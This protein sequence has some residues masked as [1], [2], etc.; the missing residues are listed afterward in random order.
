MRNMTIG[1]AIAKLEAIHTHKPL[2]AR[3]DFCMAVPTLGGSYRGT[4]REFALG[5]MGEDAYYMGVNGSDPRPRDEY[6]LRIA[7]PTYDLLLKHLREVIGISGWQMPYEGYKGGKYYMY[8]DTPL[9]VDTYGHASGTAIVD[10]EQM[11]TYLVIIR[12]A[13]VS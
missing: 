3:Y 2:M 4:Y 6:A 13:Y 12:T 5:W 9:W 10:I 8:A 7:L 11:G 1:E